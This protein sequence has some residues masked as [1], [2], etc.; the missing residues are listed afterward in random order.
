MSINGIE[1][2]RFA[3]RSQV[4]VRL[5]KSRVLLANP[6]NHDEEVLRDRRHAFDVG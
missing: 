5:H 4:I 6:V 3:K 2:R 1:I